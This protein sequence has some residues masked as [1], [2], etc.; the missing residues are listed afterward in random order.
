MNWKYWV[1]TKMKPNRVRKPGDGE[2]AAGEPP[3]REHRH[4]EHRMGATVLPGDERDQNDAATAKPDV[5]ALPPAPV[6]GLDHAVDQGGDADEDRISPPTSTGGVA[7]S[8][9]VGTN[10]QPPTMAATATGMLTEKIAPQAEVFEQPTPGYR[11]GGH[12][13]TTIAAHSPIALA[14][15]RRR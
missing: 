1:M 6:G 13:D 8:R 12:A 7:G 2:A 9:E 10:N 15:A 4:V 3:V 5:R 11:P 14:R